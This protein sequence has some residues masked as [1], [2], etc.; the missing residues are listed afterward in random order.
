MEVRRLRTSEVIDEAVRELMAA[1]KTELALELQVRGW[2]F[3]RALE[4]FVVDGD[5]D[6]PPSVF[7]S[8]EVPG[9]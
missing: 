9:D 6:M 3:R 1:G 8:L 5:T 7:W 4:H 2:R